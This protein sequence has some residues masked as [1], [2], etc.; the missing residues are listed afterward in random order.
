VSTTTP[1][2]SEPRADAAPTRDALLARIDEAWLS[3]RLAVAAAG[4]RALDTATLASAI[5]RLDPE[6]FVAEERHPGAA[7]DRAFEYGSTV[8]VAGSI[9]LVGAVRGA[10]RGHAILR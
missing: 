9:F 10:L 2:T 5:R 4:I 1:A 8:C 6:R 7:V 3:F